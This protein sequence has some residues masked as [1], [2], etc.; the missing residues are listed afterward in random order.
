MPTKIPRSIP[1]I[2]VALSIGIAVLLIPT[3]VVRVE[4][5]PTTRTERRTS[6]VSSTEVKTTMSIETRTSTMSST[7]A[8]TGFLLISFETK[9]IR[10]P[11]TLTHTSY[12]T[13]TAV[14]EFPWT[15]TEIF[16]TLVT[17]TERKSAASAGGDILEVLAKIFSIASGVAGVASFIIRL[18]QAR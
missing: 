15:K 4:P 7:I 8:A 6:T 5:R 1:F 2:L 16:A 13:R 14:W 10:V 17:T 9:V 18:R 11:W 3:E 12:V